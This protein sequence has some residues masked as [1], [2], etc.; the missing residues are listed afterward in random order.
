MNPRV[1][2]LE[3]CITDT[4]IQ[5]KPP[6]EILITYRLDVM[7]VVFMKILDISFGQRV[8]ALH[9]H[10]KP[11]FARDHPVDGLVEGESRRGLRVLGRD[12]AVADTS[13]NKT[14]FLKLRIALLTK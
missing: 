13:N 7:V 12:P 14:I 9:G 1:L 11:A 10:D 2:L 3:D 8:H 5:V 6:Q 4:V